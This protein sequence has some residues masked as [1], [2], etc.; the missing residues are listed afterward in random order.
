MRARLNL[1]SFGLSVL[2]V[3]ACGAA[4]QSSAR[5]PGSGP[6]LAELAAGAQQAE[7][8][9]GTSDYAPGR[10]RISFL[11]ARSD[12]TLVS[13][14][15]A[16]VW[17]A[18]ERSS[19]PLAQATA[20]LEVITVPGAHVSPYGTSHLFVVRTALSHAGK[21]W[22]LVRPIG[23][24]RLAAL[25]AFVVKTWTAA[26]PVGA[27]AIAS[28]TPTLGSSHGDLRA[29][30]THVPPDRALLRYSVAA[31]LAGHHPFVLVFASPAICPNRTCGPVV[32]VV[33]AVR[34]RLSGNGV[35][36]IHVELYRASN[37][38]L[39][40]NQ[41][42]KQWHLPGEPFVFLVGP[43]GRIKAKFEGSVSA[44]ELRAA[45]RSELQA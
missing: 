15:R 35:R 5:S 8:I 1:C 17:I 2:L 24:R 45:V 14:N 10:I 27:N 23:G 12:G 44:G 34:R 9:F 32:D 37:P 38:G 11:L 28:Q 18:A 30:T 4:S 26:L 19:A 13:R 33:E 25:A 7:L 20:Q 29:I 36:F 22:L 3:S 41:W 31:S 16:R 6:T 43:D 21:Y 40:L 39:G 42:A